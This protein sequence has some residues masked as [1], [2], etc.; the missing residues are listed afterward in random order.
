MSRLLG[1]VKSYLCLSFVLVT[2]ACARELPPCFIE[3]AAYGPAGEPAAFRITSVQ[4]QQNDGIEGL[5]LDAKFDGQE[6]RILERGSRLYFSE[7]Y[8]FE[9]PWQVTLT[10][11]IGEEA[12]KEITVRSC[13]QQRESLFIGKPV[14]DSKSEWV[15]KSGRI[16]GC[17]LDVD[18]WIRSS[19]LF[20]SPPG[21]TRLP[22]DTFDAYFDHESGVF[23]IRAQRYLR[24]LVTVGYR[25]AP[26]KVFAV[27]LDDKVADSDLADFDLSGSC[28]SADE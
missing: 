2:S 7:Q 13:S 21:P 25:S 3:F 5:G 22:T 16:T 15:E 8:L 24:Q 12:V 23:V 20:G 11:D 14:D 19:P 6:Y 1:D 18:W 27:N 9:A 10:S 4:I 28:P 26:V 17:P